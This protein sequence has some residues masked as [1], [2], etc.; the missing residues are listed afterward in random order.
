M[1]EKE[2]EQVLSA[3]SDRILNVNAKLTQI[4]DQMGSYIALSTGNQAWVSEPSPERAEK[5]PDKTPL[6]HEMAILITALESKT[7]NLISEIN[8]VVKVIS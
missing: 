8:Y 6:L 2:Q 4:K 3:L 7:E 1:G 5:N